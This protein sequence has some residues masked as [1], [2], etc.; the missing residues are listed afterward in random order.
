MTDDLFPQSLIRQGLSVVP[1]VLGRI[2]FGPHRYS[3][4]EEALISAGVPLSHRNDPQ[5]SLDAAVSM[6]EVSTHH[7]VQILTA[8]RLYGPM[9][10]HQ[11]AERC[12]FDHWSVAARRLT[13]L[14]D[15]RVGKVE[16]IETGTFD[17]KPIYLTRKTPSGRQAC[18]WR[19]TI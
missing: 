6:R 15:P 3:L 10:S 2:T 17:G 7:R 16:K 11:C 4:V 1:P 12:G 5:T 9:T 13:E 8:L 18:V 19:L 14:A